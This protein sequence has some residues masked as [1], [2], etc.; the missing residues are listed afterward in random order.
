MQIYDH[1][2]QDHAVVQG[3]LTELVNLAEDDDYRSV[4]IDQIASALIP[5]A[6]A[7]ESVFYNTIR[8][9]DSDTGEVMHGYKEHL[10][11]EGTLRMLQA[12]NKS[13][14]SWKATA[15]KLK[16]SLEHHIHEE[17]TQIFA[18]GKRIFS[19]Q[20]AESIGEAF[21]ELKDKIAEQGGLANA[22]ELVKNLIPPRFLDKMSGTDRRAGI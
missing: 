19:A 4:L 11:A 18:Q 14:M 1:L 8:A 2:K 3:L 17:E 21:I 5:H 9:V 12:M 10:E 22:F 16:E 13:D 7:E 6:R 20:E 15:R